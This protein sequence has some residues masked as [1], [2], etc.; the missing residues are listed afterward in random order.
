LT[1]FKERF[2]NISSLRNLAQDPDHYSDD[3]AEGD[4]ED[5]EMIDRETEMTNKVT[6]TSSEM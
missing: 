6:K 3:E 1:L 4:D 5:W 2:H